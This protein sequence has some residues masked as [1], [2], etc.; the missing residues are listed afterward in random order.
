MW[1]AKDVILEVLNK[2]K[3]WKKK[4]YSKLTAKLIEELQDYFKELN[5]R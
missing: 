5:F 2:R 3:E 4:D 1:I